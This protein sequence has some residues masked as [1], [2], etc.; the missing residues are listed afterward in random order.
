MSNINDV[1][2]DVRCATLT[3]PPAG[4]AKAESDPLATSGVRTTNVIA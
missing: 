1:R 3:E 2:F 4:A